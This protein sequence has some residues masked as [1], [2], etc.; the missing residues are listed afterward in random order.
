MDNLLILSIILFFFS[1]CVLK[2]DTII[3][4]IVWIYEVWEK[5]EINDDFKDWALATGRI[6]L[7][8]TDMGKAA[9]WASFRV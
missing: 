5:V 7:P 8:L 1:G 9:G 3:F 2:E 4:P 6:G